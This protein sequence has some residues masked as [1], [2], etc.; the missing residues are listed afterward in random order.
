[1]SGV[2]FTAARGAIGTVGS[3]W[4]RLE[5]DNGTAVGITVDPN[6]DPNG[7]SIDAYLVPGLTKVP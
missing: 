2:A 4:F 7:F 3:W 5:F 6:A 1:V